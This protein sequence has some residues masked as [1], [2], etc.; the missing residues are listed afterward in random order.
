[1][2]SLCGARYSHSVLWHQVVTLTGQ[3][4]RP[5]GLLYPPVKFAICLHACYH[6]DTHVAYDAT[7]A[8][9]CVV[10]TFVCVTTTGHALMSQIHAYLQYKAST[11]A[12][13][14]RYQAVNRRV[15]EYAV[16][17]PYPPYRP[18][19]LLREVISDTKML[20]TAPKA[21]RIDSLL[22][23]PLVREEWVWN[24]SI[25][26]NGID[27]HFLAASDQMHCTALVPLQWGLFIRKT[28]ATYKERVYCGVFRYV[29]MWSVDSFSPSY[30]PEKGG[31]LIQ[32]SGTGF[33]R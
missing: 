17:A 15:A 12:G 29:A 32:V 7:R 1:M 27:F 8:M 5:S 23:G 10:L 9:K 14:C 20:C 24:V 22:A 31:S 6:T 21:Y 30:G 19:P 3:Y 13:V 28:E 33:V 18:M 26:L 11:D 2:H 25:S 16:V 4:L